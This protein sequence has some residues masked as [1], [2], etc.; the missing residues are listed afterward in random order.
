V[1]RLNDFFGSGASSVAKGDEC[2]SCKV[3]VPRFVY[4]TG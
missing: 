4:A 1:L 3:V 2:S